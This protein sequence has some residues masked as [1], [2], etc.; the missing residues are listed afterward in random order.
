M[1]FWF[2][3]LC[4]MNVFIAFINEGLGLWRTS[5]SVVCMEGGRVLVHF[6]ELVRPSLVTVNDTISSAEGSRAK[7]RTVIVSL[8][9]KSSSTKFVVV[10]AVDD[11]DDDDDD[12]GGGGGGSGGGGGGGGGDGDGDGKTVEEAVTSVGDQ[13]ISLDCRSETVVDKLM[14]DKEEDGEGE[15]ECDCCSPSLFSAWANEQH[16]RC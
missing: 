16:C 9:G 6:G 5:C 2:V 10:V 12:G 3:C 1:Y 15:V 14:E 13:E 4:R 8:L 7:T 11:D